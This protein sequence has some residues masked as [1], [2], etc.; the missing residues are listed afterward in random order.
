[1]KPV[2]SEYEAEVVNTWAWRSAPSFTPIY[3]RLLRWPYNATLTD[4]DTDDISLTNFSV[5]VPLRNDSQN[6]WSGLGSQTCERTCLPCAL[7]TECHEHIKQLADA[8]DKRNVW[9]DRFG[10]N[11]FSARPITTFHVVKTIHIKIFRNCMASL[12]F[13]RSEVDHL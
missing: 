2:H 4:R 1:M 7:W 13:K 9:Y 8:T 12:F 11:V 3:N 6:A 10:K 5:D